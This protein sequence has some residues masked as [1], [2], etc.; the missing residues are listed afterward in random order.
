LKSASARRK[1]T[2]VASQKKP[3]TRTALRKIEPAKNAKPARKP[4]AAERE[5]AVNE[6]RR[7][8]NISPFQL[9]RWLNTPESKKL[10]YMEGGVDAEKYPGRNIL[11]ILKTRSGKYN[12]EDLDYMRRVT[13]EITRRIAKRPK[14]DII[15]SNWRYSLMNWGHDPA[16]PL[17]RTRGR[18][19]EK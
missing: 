16:K 2:R 12:G 17:K 9:E 4:K 8:V 6:F 18:H 15:A 10:R 3:T 19:N 7:V 11:K 1:N 13:S 14:G 5:V